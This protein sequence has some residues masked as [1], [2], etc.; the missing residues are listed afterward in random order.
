MSTNQKQYF[1]NPQELRHKAK[2]YAE[3]YGQ[4]KRMG[5]CLEDLP[6]NFQQSLFFKEYETEWVQKQRLLDR[7][8]VFTK[9]FQTQ[10]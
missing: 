7:K 10:L 3:T 1:N 5:L 6:H 2:A 8:I 9:Q 4:L